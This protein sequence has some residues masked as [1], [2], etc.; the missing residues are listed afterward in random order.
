MR[1]KNLKDLVHFDED[2]VRRETLFETGN[3]WSEVLCFDS[4]QFLGP[5]EDP[6]A[7]AIFT[8]L[9]GEGRFNVGRRSKSL[10]QWGTLLVPAGASVTVFN[11]RDEPMVLLVVASP[12]P[13]G[14]A[15][16]AA[17]SDAIDAEFEVDEEVDEDGLGSSWDG[18]N[19]SSDVEELGDRDR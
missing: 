15:S 10:R 2:A 1:S 17:G 7:D 11:V 16:E 13:A 4:K 3:L 8:V 6:D 9:A 12:P 14:E 19:S 5:M 18:P